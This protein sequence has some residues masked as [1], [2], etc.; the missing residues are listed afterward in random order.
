MCSKHFRSSV[1]PT[2]YEWSSFVRIRVL[3]PYYVSTAQLFESVLTKEEHAFLTRS[4]FPFVPANNRY[5][6]PDIAVI[7]VSMKAILLVLSGISDRPGNIAGT[8]FLTFLIE[9]FLS[10]CSFSLKY[11]GCH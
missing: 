9:S 11:H 10:A 4:V 7:G 3:I 6:I 8:A 5:R 2:V 1:V